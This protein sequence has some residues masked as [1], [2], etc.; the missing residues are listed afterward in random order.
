MYTV[1]GFRFCIENIFSAKYPQ[2]THKREMNER[3]MRESEKNSHVET[4]NGYHILLYNTNFNHIFVIRP[5][6]TIAYRDILCA[7]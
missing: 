6:A 2:N 7:A 4:S 1:T 3:W 5:M